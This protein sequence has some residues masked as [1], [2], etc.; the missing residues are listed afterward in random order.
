MARHCFVG[1]D[2]GNSGAIAAVSDGRA[3]VFPTPDRAHV[4]EACLF[5]RHEISRVPYPVAAVEKVHAFPGQGVS[6]SF[7]FGQAY[8]Q[9]LQG[10]FDADFEILYVTPRTWQ[11][12][13]NLPTLADCDG[14]KTVKK[15]AHKDLATALYPA[16]KMTHAVADALLIAHYFEATTTLPSD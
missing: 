3:W 15:N 6:S 8:G 7:T 11:R 5:L 12:Y 16:I 4:K 2:P 13:L 14:S 10:L 1:G 9:L